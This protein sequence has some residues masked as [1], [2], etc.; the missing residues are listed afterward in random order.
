M[1]FLGLPLAH[2]SS[3]YL[4]A[5][6]RWSPVSAHNVVNVDDDVQCRDDEGAVQQWLGT[7]LVG[8]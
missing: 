2:R 5:A 8:Q 1:P 6:S 7:W 3:A 4:S